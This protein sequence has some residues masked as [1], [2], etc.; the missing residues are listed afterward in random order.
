MKVNVKNFMFHFTTFVL[1]AYK[2][3]SVMSEND[4]KVESSYYY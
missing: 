2:Y 1:V 4:Y 3:T